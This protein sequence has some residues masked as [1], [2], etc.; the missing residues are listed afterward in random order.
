VTE[1]NVASRHLREVAPEVVPLPETGTG[2]RSRRR[3]ASRR[4]SREQLLTVL[5]L[6]AML[7]LTVVVLL[8]KWMDG[9]SSGQPGQSG[10]PVQ[11]GA[12]P[13]HYA[14]GP[15]APVQAA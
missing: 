13:A 2:E 15:G 1:P 7:A 11:S 3:R 12:V 4:Q 14:A 10:Q 9:T 6:V 8:G 5:I